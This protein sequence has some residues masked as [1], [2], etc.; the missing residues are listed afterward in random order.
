MPINPC[1]DRF[2][3]EGVLVGRLLA[4]FG[5]LEIYV[6]F[7]AEKATGLTR[8]VPIALYRIRATRSR[9]EAADGLMRAIF[10]A[11]NLEDLYGEAMSSV[12]YCQ[13]IRNQYAHCN[14]AD[15]PSPN[16]SAGLFFAD[17]TASAETSDFE[18]FWKHVDPLILQSQL[19]YFEYTLEA[20]RFIDHELAVRQGRLQSH[21][22][23]KPQVLQRPPLHNPELQHIPPWISADA[24]ALHVA[25][26]QAAL[27]GD[28]TPTPAHLKMEA[29]REAKRA[30][31][32]AD[33][34]RLKRSDPESQK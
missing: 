14:W 3:V 9:L 29:A 5:E 16:N 6:C 33:R 7:L 2:P 4:S 18:I 24:K 8:S 27:G 31:R 19:D 11:N 13:R 32:Q 28:P 21:V 34:D 1:F 30:Q 25:R 17:L 10:A 23:P 12:F 26:A 22:W 15:D 20:L